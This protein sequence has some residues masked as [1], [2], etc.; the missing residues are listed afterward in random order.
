[1]GGGLLAC[2]ALLAVLEEFERCEAEARVTALGEHIAARLRELVS[3][4]I[5]VVGARG[6]GAMWGV[7]LAPGIDAAAVATRIFERGVL[8]LRAPSVLRLL[9][10]YMITHEEID[11]AISTIAD[12]L[13]GS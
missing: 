5:G 8:V 2:A 9:P 6:L 4:D 3:R 1:M 11:V 10:P 12:A 7:A 13:Q